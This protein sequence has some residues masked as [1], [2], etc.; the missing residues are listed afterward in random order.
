MK[1]SQDMEITKMVKT[2]EDRLEA[3]KVDGLR[4]I[5]KIEKDGS[6]YLM[7]KMEEVD[8]RHG[9]EVKRLRG[10]ME[11]REKE[12]RAET[13][14]AKDSLKNKHRDEMI[15]LERKEEKKR[16]LMKDEMRAL[17]EAQINELKED[18]NLQVQN[19][20]KVLVGE[21][22]NFEEGKEILKRDC[23]ARIIE[24]ENKFQRERIGMEE[25][26]SKQLFL[27]EQKLATTT[28]K[29]AASYE[30]RISAL[31]GLL[32]IKDD[33]VEELQKSMRSTYDYTRGRWL[34][35]SVSGRVAMARKSGGSILPPPLTPLSV[36]AAR[37]AQET[38]RTAVRDTSFQD[39][40]DSSMNILG[41]DD[42]EWSTKEWSNRRLRHPPPNGPPPPRPRSPERRAWYSP[43]LER[44]AA[45]T[46]ERSR[47]DSRKHVSNISALLARHDGN[48][49]GGRGESRQALQDPRI[50]V[51][52]TQ[53]LGSEIALRVLRRWTIYKRNAFFHMWR[54]F[55]TKRIFILRV[56][57]RVTVRMSKLY[58]IMS[59][60]QWINVVREIKVKEHEGEIGMVYK[61]I[62]LTVDNKYDEFVGRMEVS[63]SKP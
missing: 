58:L 41:V 48:F 17:H 54:D 31:Q 33:K 34:D 11:R 43:G 38:V 35:E 24:A 32:K 28:A 51:S 46:I 44:S 39:W 20:R 23:E 10:M 14:F 40:G 57:R 15:D 2:W 62:E 55:A 29:Q 9:E 42:V 7:Q 22:R 50:A 16:R 6:L 26:S 1:E 18:C 30:E 61:Q 49:G 21:Q 37:G 12:A 8:A 36:S 4:A 45:K 59:W 60:Y 52:A 19:I 5:A 56:L 25:R 47:E 53:K 63:G 13:D 3:S 27:T